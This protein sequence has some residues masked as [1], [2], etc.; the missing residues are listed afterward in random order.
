MNLF[1]LFSKYESSKHGY[2]IA[3]K[4]SLTEDFTTEH[5]AH[6]TK[7]PLSK[8]DFTTEYAVPVL[9]YK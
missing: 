4:T 7:K 6:P 5:A 2:E 1:A 8:P 3:T 9:E